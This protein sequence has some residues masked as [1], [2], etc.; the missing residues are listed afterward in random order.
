[1]KVEKC[2][3]FLLKKIANRGKTK[4]NMKNDINCRE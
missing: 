4:K 3:K 1:M 2:D